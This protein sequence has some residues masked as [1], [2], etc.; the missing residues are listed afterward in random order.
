MNYLL[1]TI[2]IFTVTVAG[3]P[4]AFSRLSAS[5]LDQTSGLAKAK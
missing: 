1:S 5:G 4:G 3:S 2:K